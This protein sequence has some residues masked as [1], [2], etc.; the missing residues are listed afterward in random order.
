M[1]QVLAGATSALALMT[2][3][4]VV[5]GRLF[6]RLPESLSSSLPLGE[7]AAAALLVFF[8]VRT[9]QEALAMPA[10]PSGDDHEELADAAAEVDKAVQARERPTVNCE[11]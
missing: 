9:L 8:G 10:R 6:S 1:R 7:Y 11:L 4:S 3:I 2:V 5:I